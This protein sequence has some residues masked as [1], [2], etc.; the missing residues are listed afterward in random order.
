MRALIVI[1]KIGK[2]FTDFLCRDWTPAE[3]IL[4]ATCCVLYGMILGF[5]FSP[6][7]KGLTIG[8]N[9]GNNY[10]NCYSELDDDFMFDD[11]D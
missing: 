3:K 1:K 9:N 11:E 6:V 5:L 8:C 7:K 4:V 2:S 10:G